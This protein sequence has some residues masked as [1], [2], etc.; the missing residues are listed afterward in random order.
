MSAQPQDEYPT[1]VRAEVGRPQLEGA[2]AP[3]SDHDFQ[4]AP[5][6]LLEVPS[7][8]VEVRCECGDSNCAGEITLSLEE[9]E[10]VRVHPRRFVIKEGHEVGEAVRVVGYGT[11]YVVV[12]KYQQGPFSIGGL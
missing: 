5:S 3:P 8:L 4:L 12:A 6:Q 1:A 7:Q 9:Y 10:E 11:G 2:S